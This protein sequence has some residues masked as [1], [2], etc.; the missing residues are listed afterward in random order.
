VPN[1][2]RQL[3][4]AIDANVSRVENMSTWLS[5]FQTTYSET[6]KSSDICYI[7]V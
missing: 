6:P 3:Q 2:R 5:M 4:M 1:F 7:V